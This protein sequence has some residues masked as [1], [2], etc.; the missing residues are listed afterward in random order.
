MCVGRGFSDCGRT[1]P[2]VLPPPHSPIIW[3]ISCGD[4]SREVAGA[5]DS[6]NGLDHAKGKSSTAQDPQMWSQMLLGVGRREEARFQHPNL[7]LD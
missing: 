4:S 5:G 6:S 7:H 2:A 3:I 1:C